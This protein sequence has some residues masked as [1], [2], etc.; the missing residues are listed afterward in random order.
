MV[1]LNT[2]TG[3]SAET[4]LV[5]L[6]WISVFGMA[7]TPAH[8]EWIAS[9]LHVTKKQLKVALEYLV[10]ESYLLK[11]RNYCLPDKGQK[12]AVKYYY[13]PVA[14][15]WDEWTN[16]LKNMKF[17]DVF[18]YALEG[19]MYHASQST[20]KPKPLN[21]SERLTLALLISDANSACYVVGFDDKSNSRMIGMPEFKLREIIQTLSK[22]GFLRIL[23]AGAKTEN[24]PRNLKS[25]YTINVTSPNYKFIHL[26]LLTPEKISLLTERLASQQ[27]GQNSYPSQF[28]PLPDKHYFELSKFFRNKENFLFVHHLCQSMIFSIISDYTGDLD[29]NNRDTFDNSR[30][31]CRNKLKELVYERLSEELFSGKEISA[32][33]FIEVLENSEPDSDEALAAIRHYTLQQLSLELSGII[34]NILKELKL[35]IDIYR[36][37]VHVTGYLLKAVMV[38]LLKS[39][40]DRY[41]E[42]QNQTEPKAQVLSQS[43]TSNRAPKRPGTDFML[44]VIVPN[45]PHINDCLVINDELFAE[46]STLKDPRIQV[47]DKVTVIRPKTAKR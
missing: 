4:R 20:K 36:V 11:I 39:P 2:M 44:K 1:I 14:E 6:N 17:P 37:P 40:K 34:N 27:N 3:A 41:T 12:K 15:C 33:K 46:Q 16:T 18:K 45:L 25:I 38:V 28:P 31:S 23:S 43:V 5:F 7:P 29:C 10:E 47:V 13:I 26:G 24:S 8:N 32:K 19:K 22:S 21:A 42:S 35:F 9:V 30:L